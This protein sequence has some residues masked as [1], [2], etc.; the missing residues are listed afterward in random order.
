MRKPR[1]VKMKIEVLEG[2]VVNLAHKELLFLKN[3]IDK[4]MFDYEK[5]F[6]KHLAK[7][8]HGRVTQYIE[9]EDIIKLK[10]QNK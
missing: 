5:D 2:K 1:P 6:Q 10:K 8:P 9:P 3:A 4:T 7:T